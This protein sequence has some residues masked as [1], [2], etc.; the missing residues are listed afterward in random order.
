[1]REFLALCGYEPHEIETESARVS[2]ALA[3]VG[4]T[5]RTWL[6]ASNASPPT[7]TSS[8]WA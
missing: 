7:T 3:R 5:S 4:V 6:R 8:W 1:M 2:T